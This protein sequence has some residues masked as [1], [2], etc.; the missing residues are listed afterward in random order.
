MIISDE[1]WVFI[2][3]VLKEFN[4]EILVEFLNRV[5]RIVNEYE[6]KERKDKIIVYFCMG[7]FMNKVKWFCLQNYKCNIKF[8]MYFVSLLLNCKILK[9]V[10]EI[11]YDIFVVLLL[12]NII[13][14]NR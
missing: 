11:L 10:I 12:K 14:V 6:L 1:L 7:Y 13:S 3:V 5:W 8:G 9:V 2:I 4:I